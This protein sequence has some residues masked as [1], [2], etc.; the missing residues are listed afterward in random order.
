[1]L[2]LNLTEHSATTTKKIKNDNVKRTL[3]SV[4]KFELEQVHV[5]LLSLSEDLYFCQKCAFES[6]MRQ[7]LLLNKIV[8]LV[9]DRNRL[10]YV[11]T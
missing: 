9:F 8:K 2:S 4:G 7:I 1:M 11:E 6:T 10:K 3:M 5:L